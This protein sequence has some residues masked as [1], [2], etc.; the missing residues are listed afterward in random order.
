MI[1]L[2]GEIKK[3]EIKRTIQRINDVE[4]LQRVITSYLKNLCS[5]KFVNL[6]EI[7]SFLNIYDL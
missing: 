7:D 3:T 6:K 2:T 5:T 1:K 4:E